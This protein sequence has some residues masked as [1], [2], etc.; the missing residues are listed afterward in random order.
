MATSRRSFFARTAGLLAGAAVAPSPVAVGFPVVRAESAQELWDKT[1]RVRRVFTGRD[2]LQGS[3]RFSAEKGIVPKPG[4]GWAGFENGTTIIVSQCEFAYISD[5]S[6]PLLQCGD[7]ATVSDI[8][9]FPG[10]EFRGTVRHIDIYGP[11]HPGLQV[12]VKLDV[13]TVPVSGEHG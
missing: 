13:V 12:T 6:L 1:N 2:I 3:L 10:F 9:G 4:Q 7:E 5:G 11:V 8:L